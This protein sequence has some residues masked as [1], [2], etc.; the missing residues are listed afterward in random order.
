MTATS[1]TRLTDHDRLI[2]AKA[3]ALAA[4]SGHDE[5]REHL[6][7]RGLIEP[8]RP[9]GDLFPFAFGVAAH[10]LGNLADLAERLGG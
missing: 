10:L 9:D 8:G 2:I 4:T 5:L 6:A 3:R 1:V 7:D